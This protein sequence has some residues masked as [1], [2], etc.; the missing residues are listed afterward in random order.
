M[1]EYTKAFNTIMKYASQVEIESVDIN[2]ALGRILAEDIKSDIDIPPFNRS[3]VDGYA[4]RMEDLGNELTVVETIVAGSVPT[5]KIG[6]NECAKIMT[7]AIVPNGADCVVMVEQTKE[8]SENKIEVLSDKTP[9]NICYRGEDVKKGSVVLRK[10]TRILP[11]HIA[12]LASVGCVKPKVYR[13]IR[14]GIIVTG[15]EVIEP[16]RKPKASQI[17]NSNSYQLFS[18]LVQVG[19]IPKYYGI[20]RD[21]KDEIAFLIRK[22]SSECDFLIISG[23]VSMGEYDL[24]PDALAENKFRILFNKVSI[25]PGKPTTFAVSDG[26]KVCFG[27]PGNPVTTF[28]VFEIMVKPFAFKMMG[29]NFSPPEI[30]LPLAKSFSQRIAERETWHPVKIDIKGEI[31]P[32]EYHGSGHFLALADAD[33]L[34]CIPRGVV[35]IRKGTKVPVRLIV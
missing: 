5:R 18:Q 19:A 8:V 6:K 7:G 25:K 15:N 33:G 14:V 35:K 11:Q 10:G 24:V 13:R 27:L 23:G 20:A 22:A 1:I 4:C 34:I 9:T 16:H 28:V 31:L 30:L 12:I 21:D 2:S 3:A 32:L 17:R 26:G 29:H